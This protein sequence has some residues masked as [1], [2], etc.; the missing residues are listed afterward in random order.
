MLPVLSADGSYADFSDQ[1]LALTKYIFSRLR[2]VRDEMLRKLLK[3][4]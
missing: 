1:P 4:A 2:P 3:F